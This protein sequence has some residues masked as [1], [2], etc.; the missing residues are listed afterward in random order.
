MLTPNVITGPPLRAAIIVQARM[1]ASRLPGKPLMEVLGKPLLFYLIERLKR[2]QKV[3]EIVIAIPDKPQDAILKEYCE[4]LGVKVVLGDED[5]VLA[6]YGLAAKSV[7]CDLIVRVTADCPLMDPAV[8]DA[9]IEEFLLK[10]DK[11]DYLSNTLVRTFPRGLDVEIFTKKALE[12]ALKEA[13]TP[14]EKEHVTPYFYQH[15]ESFRLEN[16]LYDQDES[17]HRWTVDTKEDF[18]LIKR[19]LEALYPKNPYFNL[20]DMLDLIK[21]HPEWEDLNRHVEQKSL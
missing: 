3:H 8:I 18:E 2:C 20:R 4:S 6:R 16:F 14:V 11:L 15:P 17:N 7:D 12:M 19:M 5:N 1:G 21:M 9:M 13:K 10:K